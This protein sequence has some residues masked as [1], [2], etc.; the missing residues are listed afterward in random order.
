MRDGEEVRHGKVREGLQIAGLRFGCN[1]SALS[2]IW[3]TAFRRERR[4]SGDQLQRSFFSH[5]GWA[6]MPGRVAST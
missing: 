3:C 2:S 5:V 1:G 6:G 4:S